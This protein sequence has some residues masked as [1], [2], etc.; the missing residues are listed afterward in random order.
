MHSISLQDQ[1]KGL[2]MTAVLRYREIWNNCLLLSKAPARICRGRS[3][4]IYVVP[5]TCSAA[6][7]NGIV[8]VC[9]SWNCQ[10]HIHEAVLDYFLANS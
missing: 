2:G 3:N 8:S 4:V 6:V 9:I 5:I 10:A 1:V 7:R